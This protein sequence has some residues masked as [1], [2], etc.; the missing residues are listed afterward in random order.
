[1]TAEHVD[2]TPRRGADRRLLWALGAAGVW[3]IVTPYLGSLLGLEVD[4]AA[5]VE[6]VDHVV[7]GAVVLL[8]SAVA[9]SRRAAS[10]DLQSIAAIGLAF[11]AGFWV[12]ST[13]VPLIAEAAR[14]DSPWDATV[15]HNSGGFLIAA[16]SLWLLV[17]PLFRAR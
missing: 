13:H 3:T 7:P 8:T 9:L 5:T 16:L 14:G 11:L 15:W 17:G 4:V 6:V 12:I 2:T 10:E 1:V